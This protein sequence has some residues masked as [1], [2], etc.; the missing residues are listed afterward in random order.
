MAITLEELKDSR[1]TVVSATEKSL[2]RIFMVYGTDDPEEAANVGPQINEFWDDE[3]RVVERRFESPIKPSGAGTEEGVLK[4]TVTYRYQIVQTS[5]DPPEFTINLGTVSERVF[6]TPPWQELYGVTYAALSQEHKGAPGA[7]DAKEPGDLINV[8]IDENGISVEGV[9][10]LMPSVEY[11]E[12]HSRSSLPIAQQ[13][14][15]TRLTAKVNSQEW[16][17]W[18]AGAVLFLGAT[19]SKRKGESWKITYNFRIGANLLHKLA[20]DTGAVIE[21]TK[22]AHDYVW[23]RSAKKRDAITGIIEWKI[24]DVHVASVYQPDDFAEL[25]IGSEAL[26]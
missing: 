5:G 26:S 25:R 22:G 23:F 19:A 14:T 16:R 12:T 15:I 13:M 3:M 11:T 7:D 6:K 10:V 17:G 1:E 4:L 18:P 24:H 8:K 20:V 2:M 9:D 21:Y